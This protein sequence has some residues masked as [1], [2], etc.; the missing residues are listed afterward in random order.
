MW[1][2]PNAVTAIITAV[3][4]SSGVGAILA[5]W[6]AKS[7]KSPSITPDDAAAAGADPAQKYILQRLQDTERE[8]K[9]EARKRE[10]LAEDLAQERRRGDAQTY[11]IQELRAAREAD[12]ARLMK[13]LI[14]YR[15]LMAYA[16][17]IHSR[18]PLLRQH[19]EPPPLPDLDLDF[20]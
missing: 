1:S 5:A 16:R 17:D 19:R 10:K 9:E 8:A 7:K 12:S 11:A 15:A 3:L 18:W 14:A 4:G 20:D 13:A 6:V 2:D